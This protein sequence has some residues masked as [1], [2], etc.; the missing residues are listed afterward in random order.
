MHSYKERR[1]GNLFV[2]TKKLCYKYDEVQL[3]AS[4]VLVRI[5]FVEQIILIIHLDDVRKKH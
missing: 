4:Y 2:L 5:N 1:T 3:K